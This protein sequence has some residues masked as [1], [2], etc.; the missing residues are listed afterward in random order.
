MQNIVERG[1]LPIKRLA[2]IAA[3]VPLPA[4]GLE[5]KVEGTNTYSAEKP[6]PVDVKNPTGLVY[7]VQVGAFANTIP[8]DL[9]KEFNP[10]SGEKLNN[11]VTRYMA[12]Y[13]NNSKKVIEVRDQIKGLGYADAFAVA[14]C[15]GKRISLA[16]ARILEANGECV[17]KGENELILEVA[18]NTAITKMVLIAKAIRSK[19]W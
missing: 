8:Q 6:I 12:G 17:A 4:N 14:Y 16:E 5:I 1:I 13:F 2:V 9:F 18:A 10:V 19:Y 15:D 3:L 7:R 11:G